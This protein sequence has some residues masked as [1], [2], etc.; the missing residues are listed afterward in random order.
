MSES[1]LEQCRYGSLDKINKDIEPF[2]LSICISEMCREVKRLHDSVEDWD[3]LQEWMENLGV[4]FDYLEGFEDASQIQR[5]ES[6]L[7]VVKDEYTIMY[8]K[9]IAEIMERTQ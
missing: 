4:E 6:D 1:L 3:G 5:R 9:M 2:V 7:E 8:G